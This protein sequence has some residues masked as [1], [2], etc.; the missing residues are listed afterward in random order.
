MSTITSDLTAPMDTSD[1]TSETILPRLPDRTPTAPSTVTSAP[2][3]HQ[4]VATDRDE[5]VPTAR[6]L[7]RPFWFVG[8]LLMMLDGLTTY[9][10]LE[11]FGE[12]GAREGNP[13]AQW[14]IDHLGVAGMCALKVLIGV[15]MMWRLAAT[16]DHGH[17]FE[18]LN[19][20]LVLRRRP[21]WKVQ[22]NAAWTLA[23][24]LVLMGVVVGNN[25]RAIVSL[26][27]K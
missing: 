8:A 16:A 24:S 18:W 1:A 26:W 19:R 23:F 25:V 15:A 12:H 17:R 11:F 4:P 21:R 10:A 22:R 14:A 27:A 9:I 6:Q 3:V 2:A 5:Q 20:G 13:L 7:L